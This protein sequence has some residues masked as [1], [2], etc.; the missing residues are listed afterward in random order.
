MPIGALPP[1]NGPLKPILMTSVLAVLFSGAPVTGLA[2]T[3]AD[4]A[5]AGAADFAGSLGAAGFVCALAGNTAT[6]MQYSNVNNRAAKAREVKVA[7]SIISP[8]CRYFSNK[9]PFILR[10]GETQFTHNVIT[11]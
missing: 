1:V 3:L 7:Y 9:A 6:N 10:S 5:L 11:H 8:L 4:L 2:G